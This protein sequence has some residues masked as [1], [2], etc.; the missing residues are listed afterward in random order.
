[1]L[2]YAIIG[3]GGTG[4]VIGAYMAKAGKDVTLIARGKHLDAVRNSGI[5]IERP[6]SGKHETIAVKASAMEEYNEKADVIFVC[7]KSYS[8]GDTIPF[9]KRIAHEKTIVIPILNVYGTGGRMQKDLPDLL[10]TD[11]CIYVSAY[12]NEPGVILQEGDICRIFFGERKISSGRVEA[13]SCPESSADSFHKLEKTIEK[14]LKDSGIDGVLSEN[15]E[16]DA[17]QKFSYVSPIG[18]AGLYFDVAAGDFQKEGP[19]REMFKSLIREIVALAKA[20]GITF[21]IDLV[22]TNLRIMES[23]APGA[24]TSMQRDIKDGKNSEADGLVFEVIRLAEEYG[25]AVP[26]Y[27]NAAE[28]IKQLR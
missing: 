13:I 23:L 4:G 21:E 28:K 7:V 1:M 11:G 8:L 14:D 6:Y 3:A 26:Y 15:I 27:R 16:R 19:Q 9:I 20:M 5:K 22:E 12:I 18:V 25:V 17:L 24:T 2:K 10:V